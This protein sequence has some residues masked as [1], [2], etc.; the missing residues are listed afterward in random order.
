MSHSSI[1]CVPSLFTRLY[2]E[3]SPIN[4]SKIV[5]ACNELLIAVFQLVKISDVNYSPSPGMSL[6]VAACNDI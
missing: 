3:R 1:T 2:H 4:N 5:A 6:V